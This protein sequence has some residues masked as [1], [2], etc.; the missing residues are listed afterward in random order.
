MRVGTLEIAAP[1]KATLAIHAVQEGWRPV[2]VRSV[3]L[4]PAR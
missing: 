1:G 2:N 4:Q 3:R